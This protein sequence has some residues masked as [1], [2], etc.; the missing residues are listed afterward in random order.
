MP[1]EDSLVRKAANITVSM[2]AIFQTGVAV[3][4]AYL[5]NMVLGMDAKV[6][7]LDEQLKALASETRIHAEHSKESLANSE[8]AHKAIW[9]AMRQ[10]ADKRN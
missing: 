3:I 9:D 5:L 7:R 6:A 1:E 4:I 10:K 8:T 2:T